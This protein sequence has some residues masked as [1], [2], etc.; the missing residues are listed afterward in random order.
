MHLTPAEREILPLVARG[1]T[2]KEI[3][4]ARR[5]S[6]H[7]IHRQIANLCVKFGVHDRTRLLMRVLALGLMQIDEIGPIPPQEY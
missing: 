1:L 5:R 6:P 7:T 4:R 2:D 3:A